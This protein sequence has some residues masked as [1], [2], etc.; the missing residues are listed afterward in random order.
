MS[1]APK[2]EQQERE[3]E[4]EREYIVAMRM[5]NTYVTYCTNI[6]KCEKRENIV[7]TYQPT[8]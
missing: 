8:T 1:Y 4:R 7:S 3:R 5:G 2:W 6:L